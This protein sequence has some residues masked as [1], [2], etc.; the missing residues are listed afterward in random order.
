MEINSV[1]LRNKG[2]PLRMAVVE[3][4]ENRWVRKVVDEESGDPQI[5]TVWVHFDSNTVADM[6]EVFG[7]T[8]AIQTAF[9]ERPQ[10]IL[11]KAIAL[12]LGQDERQVG[13]ALLAEDFGE[14]L[15]KVQVAWGI[16]MGLDPTQG[17]KTLEEGRKAIAVGKKKMGEDLDAQLA[18]SILASP[19]PGETGSGDGSQ[20]VEILS[21]SGV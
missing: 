16:C 21:S 15:L 2:V 5:R 19:S 17:A 18:E 14:Y 13:A 10:S 7:S 8:A 3:Q 1:L 9:E 20:P 11:R 12:A 4:R 6:E